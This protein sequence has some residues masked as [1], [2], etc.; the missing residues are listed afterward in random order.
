MDKIPPTLTVAI[1]SLRSVPIIMALIT[2]SFTGETAL[3]FSS[4]PQFWLN[5]IAFV[6][7]I[8]A[9]TYLHDLGRV[10]W[11]I[12]QVIYVYVFVILI[13]HDTYGV[14]ASVLQGN[15][16]PAHWADMLQVL[17]VISSIVIAGLLIEALIQE[18]QKLRR[19]ALR[20][21]IGLSLV[22]VASIVFFLPGALGLWCL[23]NWETRAAF[24]QNDGPR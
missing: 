8:T 9:I 17:W 21:A 23:V 6:G 3:D 5:L 7:I 1:W 16:K 24:K 14:I 11:P 18:L 10:S 12:S 15:F 13:L 22:Y 20:V 4:N 2:L 19:W